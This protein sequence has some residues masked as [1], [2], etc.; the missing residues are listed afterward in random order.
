MHSWPS[1][2]GGPIKV[3]LWSY[4]L[5]LY[6]SKYVLARQR[7]LLPALRPSLDALLA[8]DFRISNTLY[9]F[10]LAQAGEL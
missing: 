6:L 2:F 5:C 9:H 7:N 4:D 8:A 10:A 3:V 1:R